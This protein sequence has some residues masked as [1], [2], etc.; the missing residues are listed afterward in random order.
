MSNPI[1][2]NEM[3]QLTEV[4]ETLNRTNKSLRDVSFGTIPVYDA[5][6]E[7]LGW[8]IFH[9]SGEYAFVTERPVD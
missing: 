3:K 4:L 7:D 6:G 5:N 8:I 1:L 2:A 9:E